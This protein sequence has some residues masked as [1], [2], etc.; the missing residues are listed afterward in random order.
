MF[1]RRFPP[2]SVRDLLVPRRTHESGRF[3]RHQPFP[4]NA[5][6]DARAVLRLGPPEPQCPRT[7]P[8]GPGPLHQH[9]LQPQVLRHDRR[10]L[11]Q[12]ARGHL[13]REETFQSTCHGLP[14]REVPFRPSH[15]SLLVVHEDR[16]RT[17]HFLH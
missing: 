2:F 12:W 14:C 3:L 5:R 13:G 4:A 10:R 7:G 8:P 11:L 9:L 17:D 6:K 15:S 1:K 16:Y